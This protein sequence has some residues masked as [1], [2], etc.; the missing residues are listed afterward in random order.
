ML[1]EVWELKKFQTT[2]LTFKVIRRCHS[3][4]HTGFSLLD[5]HSVHCNHVSI[6]H[7]F[8]HIST[9]LKLKGHV[10]LNTSLSAVTYHSCT[11][12]NLCINQHTTSEVRSSTDSK[13]MIRG[14]A[15]F[16][17]TLHVTQTTPN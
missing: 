9:I 6:L 8:R 1:H 14:G 15:K 13:Y 10:T 12:V 3:M 2:K 7:R 11:I 17:K 5:F 4:D 16:K